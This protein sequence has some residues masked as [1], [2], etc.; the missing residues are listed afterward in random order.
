MEF[1]WEAIG[2]GAG[3]FVVGMLAVIPF[4]RGATKGDPKPPADRPL[5]PD[6]VKS[7]L[8]EMRSILKRLEKGQEE[9]ADD[10]ERSVRD[11][12]RSLDRIETRVSFGVQHFN[13]RT[14]PP[15]R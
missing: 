15:G 6:E 14:I 10:Y 3:L 7:A 8:S 9:F 12:N 11:I 1:N 2:Q 13:D 4:K 5:S